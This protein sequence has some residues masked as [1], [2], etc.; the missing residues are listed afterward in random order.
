M[1]GTK[2]LAVKLRTIVRPCPK[3]AAALTAKN[4]GGGLNYVAVASTLG[5]S[6]PALSAGITA[7]NFFAL[8]YFPLVSWLGG[9]APTAG[10]GKVEQDMVRGDVEGSVQ[11]QQREVMEG[12]AAGEAEAVACAST[13]SG[14]GGGGSASGEQDV[15]QGQGLVDGSVLA[16]ECPSA[17]S[18]GG[19]G[20]VRGGGAAAV[21]DVDVVDDVSD[22][23]DV[24]SA[25]DVDA[26]DDA[27]RETE[28]KPPLQAGGWVSQAWV[29]LSRRVG[30][31]WCCSPRHML[32]FDQQRRVQNAL[33]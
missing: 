25:K 6:P 10:G 8:L 4:I 29:A 3:L 15:V 19:G 20:S 22:V 12:G 26:R 17:S 9:L 14:G 28:M 27:A 32:L 13:S 31:G 23:D 7:D 16:V 21:D 24:V 5:V 2:R 33:R 30:F 18:G 11:G 1:S